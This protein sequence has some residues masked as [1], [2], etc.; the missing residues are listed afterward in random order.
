MEVLFEFVESCAEPS[1]LF[2]VSE[3]SFDAVACAIERPI[4]LTLFQPPPGWWNDCLDS[5]ACEVLEDVVHVIALVGKHGAG[6]QVGEKRKSLCA[7]VALSAGEQE[8]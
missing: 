2:E 5:S 8:S 3:G 6:R 4:E 1:E 7:I